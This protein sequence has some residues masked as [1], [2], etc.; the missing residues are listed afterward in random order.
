MLELFGKKLKIVFNSFSGKKFIKNTQFFAKVVVE[1][2]EK[3][4]APLE[5]NCWRISLSDEFIGPIKIFP[6]KFWFVKNSC[7]LFLF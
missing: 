3:K 4:M 6:A 1:E 2:N 7:N 5:Q